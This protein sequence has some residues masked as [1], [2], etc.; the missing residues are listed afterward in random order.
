MNI[1]TIV[2]DPSPACP[3]SAVASEHIVGSFTD[4]AAIAALAARCDVLT[5]EIEHVNVEA[6]AAAA[7]SCPN[8]VVHPSP[9]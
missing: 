7:A 4:T 5:V 3:A 6:I 1:T 2:L 9:A 8:V